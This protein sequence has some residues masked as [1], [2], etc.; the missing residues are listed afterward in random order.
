MQLTNT[1]DI[2]GSGEGPGTSPIE[3]LSEP[4]EADSDEVADI[5]DL[6]KASTVHLEKSSVNWWW[7]LIDCKS[8]SAFSLLLYICASFIFQVEFVNVRKANF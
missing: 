1:P 4:E 5:A 8:R 2:E 6:G 7:S 3:S